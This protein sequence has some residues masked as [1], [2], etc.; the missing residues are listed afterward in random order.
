MSAAKASVAPV[1]ADLPVQP[2]VRDLLNAAVTSGRVS[3]AYLFVGAP[4][5]GKTACAW[6]LASAILCENGGDGSCD[7]CRR[8]ARRA[9]PDVHAY[10]PGSATGYL[11][12]QVRDIIADTGLAPI[13]ATR[14]VYLITSADRLSASSANA[15]LKTL[16]EPPQ[17]AVFILIARTAD[18]VLPTIRSRCQVVS[19]ELMAPD[20][21]VRSVSVHSGTS[22]QDARIALAVAGS[23]E[24]AVEFLRSPERREVRRLMLTALSELGQLDE[25]DALSAAK[26]L[27]VALKAPLEEVKSAQDALAERDADF[28]TPAALK[29]LEARNK[30]ELTA[31][32]RGFVIEALAAASSLLHDVLLLCEGVNEPLVNQDYQALVNRMA[33]VLSVGQVLAALDAVSA[34]SD[35]LTHNVGPQLVLEVMLLSI[36]EAFRCRM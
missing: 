28:L 22:E 11:V 21:A 19:F 29:Q 2:R 18:S 25:W 16:E 9:H 35:N 6:A 7:N 12:D 32:E 14:K 3:H 33:S 5:S 20:A 23:P 34:A 1:F 36:K 31:R 15:L 26:N 13:R 30:R 24:R 10:A 4:G 27:T 17:S 8:V